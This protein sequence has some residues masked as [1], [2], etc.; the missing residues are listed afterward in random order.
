[1]S[2]TITF[3]VNIIFLTSFFSAF[4]QAQSPVFEKNLGQF[5]SGIEYVAKAGPVQV[6]LGRTGLQFRSKADRLSVHYLRANRLSCQTRSGTQSEVNY[7]YLK[8]ALTH[9]PQYSEVSCPHLYRGIDWVV[10]SSGKSI[11]HDWYIAPGADAS[12][13]A[14]A[15]DKGTV[16]TGPG[17]EL[18]VRSG[19]LTVEWRKPVAWQEIGKERRQV[20]VSYVVKGK[21]ISLRLAGWRRDLPLVIDPLFN[22]STVIAGSGDDRATQVGFD[23]L[24]NVYVAGLTQSSDFGTTQGAISNTASSNPGASQIYIRKLGADG[25]LI[26]STY[27]GLASGTGNHPIGMRVDTSGNVYL[28]AIIN[29]NPLA[30]NGGTIID[31]NG[32][33][34]L[35]KISSTG[36]RVIYAVRLPSAGYAALAIDGTLSAYVAAGPGTIAKIDPLGTTRTALISTHLPAGA[37]IADLGVGMDGSVYVAGSTTVPLTTTTAVTFPGYFNNPTSHGYLTRLKPDGSGAVY[38]TLISGEYKDHVYALAVDATGAAYVGGDTSSNGVSVPITGTTIRN[39]GG[40]GLP[41]TRA[42]AMKVNPAGT[43]SVWV[44]VVPGTS[45][46]ALAVDGDGNVYA[47]GGFTDGGGTTNAG[48]QPNSTGVNLDKIDAAGQNLLYALSISTINVS[49]NG[50]TA[51][52]LGLAVDQLHAVYLAGSS[53]SAR[54]P[55]WKDVSSIAPNGFVLKVDPYVDEADLQIAQPKTLSPFLP[56]HDGTIDFTITNNGPGGAADVVFTFPAGSA[57][58]FSFISC[59]STGTGTCSDL[60][61]PAAVPRVAFDSIAAGASETVTI[62]FN[63]QTGIHVTPYV[64]AATSDV[65]QA[66]NSVPI[67]IQPSGVGVYVTPRSYSTVPTNGGFTDLGL[68][69]VLSGNPAYI[70]PS[71][72]P[73]VLPDVV[74]PGS[75]FVINWPSPQITKSG[76]AMRF[77]KWDVDGDTSNPRTLVANALPNSSMTPTAFFEPFSTPYVS[78]TGVTSSG[79][80][81]AGGVAPGELITVFGFNLSGGS[82]AFQGQ[83]IDGAFTSSLGAASISFDG[84]PAPLTYVGPSQINAIVPYAIAG[85]AT[86]SVTIQVGSNSNTV[87]V[88]VSPAVP[89]LFTANGSGSGQAA[90]LNQNGTFNSVSNPAHAGD[91]IVLYGTGEGLVF[92]TPADGAISSASPPAPQLPVTVTIGNQ[93]AQVLYAADSPGLT[94]GVIQIN[95][96]IPAGIANNP[97]VPVTWSAG[98]YTSPAGT[99]IAIK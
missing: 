32:G 29:Q 51:P 28:V 86:T 80:F 65:N 41:Y 33:L 4:L 21:T 88:P 18:S 2:R 36:D 84:H 68:K 59:S 95:A 67:S 57:N 37:D 40:S 97:Q 30:G 76:S 8:P 66:N 87:Q 60:Q 39:S 15:V 55:E 96:V 45:V 89:S 27:L 69:Y 92:P 62:G 1:M 35:Y 73:G 75:E 34:G 91:V 9:V 44:A 58:G 38:T 53:A 31:P 42:F 94:A 19:R 24:D 7:L 49:N 46:S 70:S 26:Y 3:G 25:S 6:A 17:G 71:Q 12:S 52:V 98:S 5:A 16:S 23:A 50:A 81:A 64:Y 79:S 56:G 13:I 43:V 61:R 74:Y 85:Q 77:L 20:D 90:A 99:T 11:E 83:V 10:R 14:I 48:N 47:A 72:K 78:S 63:L 82:A 93:P 54:V 22:F